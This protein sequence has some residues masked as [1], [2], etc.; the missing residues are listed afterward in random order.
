MLIKMETF[1]RCFSLVYK[2]VGDNELIRKGKDLSV[3]DEIIFDVLD[4][5]ILLDELDN[6]YTLIT[7]DISSILLK[8]LAAPLALSLCIL[9]GKL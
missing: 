4:V 7:D 8:R 9:L 5:F 2:K 3:L 1:V 6:R